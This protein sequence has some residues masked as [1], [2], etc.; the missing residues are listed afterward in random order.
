MAVRDGVARSVTGLLAAVAGLS[1]AHLIAQFFAPNSSPVIAVGGAAIDAAPTPLKEWAIREFGTND[2]LILLSGIAFVLALL[3]IAIGVLACRNFRIGA[4]AMTVLGVV[5]GTA[6]LNRP[7]ADASYAIPSVVGLLVAL[8]VLWRLA[9]PPG[10][11]SMTASHGRARRVRV[12]GSR[13]EFLITGVGVG[14]VS[15]IAFAAGTQ[16]A[17]SKSIQAA[18]RAVRLPQAAD[19]GPTQPPGADPAIPGLTS[20]VTSNRDFYRV[21]TALIVPQVNPSSWQLTV[22]GMVSNPFSVSYSELLAMRMI[23]R[24]ITLTCVSNEVGGQY[25]GNA[26]WLGVPLKAFLARANVDPAAD[27]LLCRSTDGFTSSVS[28]ALALDGR[29]AMIA[30]GM[31]G[32]PLPSQHG[33]PARLV[34]PGLY[35]YVSACKWLTSIKATTFADHEAYWT[36][37][38][39]AAQ[40]P[41]LTSTRIDVPREGRAV[42]AGRVAIAGVAWAQHR[43]I[44]KVEVQID[45]G[46]WQQAN[47]APTPSIDT[48]RQWWLAW[49]ATEGHHQIRARATDRAGELQT[50]DEAPPFPSGATGWDQRT[51]SVN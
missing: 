5:A 7:T 18:R 40:A 2:K 6:A 10:A 43:G 14:A 51:I 3:A 36:Q 49:E 17:R 12:E 45:D 29:D 13:R 26:R 33:F 22:E 30:V 31:N 48:W 50:A 11:T 8:A 32:E 27:Q 24:D 35:G 39:W 41:I 34:I 23:E 42:S 38:G 9:R 20:F 28:R 1:T 44:A 19:V 25:A 46:P 21:D 37:R 47:L 16:V 15:A 4:A